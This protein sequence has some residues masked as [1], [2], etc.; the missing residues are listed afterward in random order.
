MSKRIEKSWLVFVS[1]ENDT[2]DLCVDLF[3]RPDGSCGFEA[4]RRDVEDLG[5]WTPI[6]YH[7]HRSLPSRR[8]AL[9]AAEAAVPWLREAVERHPAARAL[10]RD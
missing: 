1:I 2:H 6:G 3:E 7:A 5:A 9:E 8:A 4:F 10:S